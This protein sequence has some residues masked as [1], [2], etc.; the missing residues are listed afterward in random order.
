MEVR[1]I[2][3]VNGSHLSTK[4]PRFPDIFPLP[5]LF[6]IV[7]LRSLGIFLS[8]TLSEIRDAQRS[9]VIAVRNGI[10]KARVRAASFTP[11]L[12]PILSWIS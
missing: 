10:V 2:L 5:F 3:Q 7:F 6:A 11:I 9:E 12:S 1:E 4:I 8:I